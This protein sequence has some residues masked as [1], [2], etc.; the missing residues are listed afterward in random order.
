MDANEFAKLLR[1][2]ADGE[3]SIED[4]EDWFDANSWNVHQQ[5]DAELIAAV[6]EVEEIY[7][8][9]LDGRMSVEGVR[10]Q[11][12]RLADALRLSIWAVGSAFP[13]SPETSR[14][15]SNWLGRA[16]SKALIKDRKVYP[17]HPLP[18]NLADTSLARLE[19]I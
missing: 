15:I 1:L 5:G 2:C 18:L 4:F 7:S 10:R 19:S 8:A 14:S 12:G 11:M 9:Y 3:R 16:C 17:K 13:I 6:F